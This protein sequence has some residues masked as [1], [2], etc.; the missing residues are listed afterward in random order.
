MEFGDTY[1][2]WASDSGTWSSGC[3]TG[4]GMKAVRATSVQSRIFA[5]TEMVS[6][7]VTR[8]LVDEMLHITMVY[9]Y[10]GHWQHFR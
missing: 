10:K 4:L 2:E 6:V 9:G 7:G 5:G 1:L 3:S 8:K